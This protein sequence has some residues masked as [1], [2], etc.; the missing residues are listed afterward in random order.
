MFPSKN[1]PKC[2]KKMG[3][4]VNVL[5]VC[6]DEEARKPVPLGMPVPPPGVEQMIV[7]IV[8]RKPFNSER[9]ETPERDVEE[10]A[11]ENEAPGRGPGLGR[12]ERERRREVTGVHGINRPFFVWRDRGRRGPGPATRKSGC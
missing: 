4:P 8:R 10:T 3:P 2:K 1:C 12:L 11:A 9:D 7:P 6:R 5:I